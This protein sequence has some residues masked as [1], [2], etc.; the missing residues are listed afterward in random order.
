MNSGAPAG[1]G[2]PGG[3]PPTSWCAAGS[4]APT[5]PVRVSRQRSMLGELERSVRSG[6][7]LAVQQR[8]LDRGESLLVV[9]RE[10]QA[11]VVVVDRRQLEVRK[12]PGLRDRRRGPQKPLEIAGAPAGGEQQP[13]RTPPVARARAS[14][15]RPRAAARRPAW[16]RRRRRRTAAGQT[17]A[18]SG[19]RLASVRQRRRPGMLAVGQARGLRAERDRRHC[20]A[21]RSLR[22]RPHTPA[23]APPAASAAAPRTRPPAGQARSGWRTVSLMTPASSGR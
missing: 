10:V 1:T 7:L 16:E 12:A 9:T 15:A 3:I 2:R 14:A 6:E 8:R 22:G 23:A 5:N 4:P 21:G 17:G 13:A 20:P 11:Q 19:C 18:R